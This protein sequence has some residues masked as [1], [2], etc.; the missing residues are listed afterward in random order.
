MARSKGRKAKPKAFVYRRPMNLATD[1]ENL[2][3]SLAGRKDELI[4]AMDQSKDPT[5]WP[6]GEKLRPAFSPAAVAAILIANFHTTLKNRPIG[7]LW[8]ETL[9]KRHGKIRLGQASLSVGKVKYFGHVD[10]L[11]E[12]NWLTW[13]GLAPRERIALM[14]HELMHCD[15]AGDSLRP[16]IVP[17][18]VEE[19]GTIVHR[20]GLWKPDLQKFAETVTEA[21]QLSMFAPAAG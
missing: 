6:Q 12:I 1:F 9:Q 2:P 13:Q 7:Y 17:H 18:D 4:E 8:Q 20:W 21:A 10:F 11:I 5:E 19:F 14:D 3:G 15:V 16:Y